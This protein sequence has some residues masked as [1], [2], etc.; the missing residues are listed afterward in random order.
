M[1]VR[2]PAALAVVLAVVLAGCSPAAVTPNAPPSYQSA[3]RAHSFDVTPFN[4]PASVF[5][6][7]TSTEPTGIR[8]RYITATV[9]L[10]NG[11]TLGALYNRASKHWS[12]IAYPSAQSTAAYGPKAITH[13][14]IVV[15]SYK[16]AGQSGD[17]GFAYDSVTRKYTPIVA[18]ASLCA[19]Q[20]CNFTIAHSVYGGSAR[21][22]VVG[23]YDAAAKAPTIAGHAFIY[24][25]ATKA[26]A[27]IDV[28]NAVSTTAYGIWI[29]GKTLA[30]AGGYTDKRGRHAYVR[31]LTGNHFVSYDYP[32]AAL[33]HFEGITGAGGPGNYNV[34]GDYTKPRA[35]A[36]YGFY[37][38]IRNWKPWPPV[39]I[40]KL[41]ANSVD[42]RDVIGVYKPGSSSGTSGYIVTLP[43]QDPP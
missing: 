12:Q 7:A 8:D 36:V 15:G 2:L 29:N 20:A 9:T 16:N 4:A 39:V 25:S 19:P 24:D 37:L 18:P 35:K 13:G 27:T 40:G 17:N 38:Q 21:Y 30:V 31:D 14:A 5:P 34:V 1:R 6:G 10:S 43:V 11:T 32:K 26:F 22:I 42:M 41:T 28:P 23:N 3:L 33:T